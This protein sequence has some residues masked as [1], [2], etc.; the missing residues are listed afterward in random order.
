MVPASNSHRDSTPVQPS[1]FSSPDAIVESRG[2]QKAGAREAT[3]ESPEALLVHYFHQQFHGVAPK[4]TLSPKDLVS[5][6]RLV[7]LHGLTKAQG[8][9]D[10]AKREA[11]K[12][13]Y[14]PVSLNGILQYESRFEAEREKGERAQ[15]LRRTRQ[16]Q[17][18]QTQE[19]KEAR[20]REIIAELVE[21]VGQVKKSA[22]QAFTAFL[23]QVESEREAF[24]NTPISRRASEPMRELLSRAYEQPAKRL[25]IFLSFFKKG[26]EGEALLTVS[27]EGREVTT[28]IG[29]YGEAVRPLLERAE[30]SEDI[31]VLLE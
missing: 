4:G 11:P 3:Q 15:E 8:L 30:F 27:A 7:S 24:L 10:F 12:T 22:P 26:S 29:A 21:R 14:S 20:Q 25:E 16:Q 23:A 13:K 19:A 9:V 5:A 17:L 28:W 2:P 6:A 18:E 1:L 31:A